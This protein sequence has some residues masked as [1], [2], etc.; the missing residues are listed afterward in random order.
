MN[1]LSAETACA[2]VRAQSS[3]P[4][5]G[6]VAAPPKRGCEATFER[7]RRGGSETVPLEMTV[8]EPPRRA[9]RV[10][11]PDSGGE[12]Y[13]APRA[14]YSFTRSLAGAFIHDDVKQTVATPA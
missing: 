3:P 1:E 9:S 2:R 5:S 8:K 12:F 13:A 4:E 10:S 14:D 6:G 7:R 11:P